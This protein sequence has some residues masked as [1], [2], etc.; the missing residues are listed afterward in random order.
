M[1]GGCFTGGGNTTGGC[2]LS[3]VSSGQLTNLSYTFG[4]TSLCPR[5]VCDFRVLCLSPDFLNKQ[6]LLILKKIKTIKE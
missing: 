6:S 4:L 5:S 2:K 1:T 3:I